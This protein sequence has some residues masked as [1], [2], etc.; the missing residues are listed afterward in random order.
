M[1]ELENILIYKS[2]LTA[3]YNICLIYEK[4]KRTKDTTEQEKLYRLIEDFITLERSIYNKL[5]LSDVDKYLDASDQLEGNQNEVII[6]YRDKLLARKIELLQ[7]DNSLMEY[8]KID[9]AFFS[10][11]NINAITLT[12]QKL[13]SIKTS[14]LTTNDAD[15]LNRMLSHFHVLKYDRLETDKLSEE[16]ALSYRY[17]FDRIRP[18]NLNK[19]PGLDT[20]NQLCIPLANNA[21]EALINNHNK[22]KNP[23]NTLYSLY[24]SSILEVCLEIANID[25]LKEITKYCNKVLVS[26][27]DYQLEAGC[28]RRLIYKRK[29]EL[30]I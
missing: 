21:I 24:Y 4:L 7:K 8:L 30:G 11:I 27:K 16:Y 3:T 9:S 26:P 22:A 1:G 18:L 20:L 10:L 2:G 28:I 14:S 5:E 15:F 23:F 17:D 12:Y 6:R 25:S 29:N 19:I 13:K